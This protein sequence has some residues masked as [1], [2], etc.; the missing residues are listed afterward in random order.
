MIIIALFIDLPP[1]TSVSFL[2]AIN[3][4]FQG[5]PAVHLLETYAY[6]YMTQFCQV[7]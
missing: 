7:T 3:K 1:E 2:L 5:E 4:P 6:Q